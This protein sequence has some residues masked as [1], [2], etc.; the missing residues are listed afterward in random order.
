MGQWHWHGAR[1]K[2][3][4]FTKLK[5]GAWRVQVGRKGR[6]I[7]ETFQRREGREARW[8]SPRLAKDHSEEN[9][10]IPLRPDVLRPIDGQHRSV[11]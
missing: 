4:T 11:C 8:P 2:V 3:A 1:T 5:S 10:G 6:Y 9:R 7:G